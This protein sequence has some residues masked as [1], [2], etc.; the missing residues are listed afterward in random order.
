MVVLMPDQ[1][2]RELLTP[3]GMA[4]GHAAV[5]AAYEWFTHASEVRH[6]ER[7]KANGL[8]LGWPDGAFDVAEI[9]EAYGR[10]GQ[11][12]ICLSIFPKSS[13]LLLNKG[14]ASLFKVA[15][16]RD[17]LPPRVGI[18]CTFGGTYAIASQMKRD[19]PERT[20][21]EMFLAIVKDRE[22]VI[23]FDAIPASGLRVCPKA[24]PGAPPWEWPTLVDTDFADAAIFGPD[25]QGNVPV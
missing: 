13:I 21:G 25:I 22:I 23:S 9:I 2:L 3:E 5:V 15:L 1:F 16:P 17:S 4:D 24:A 10:A 12:I 14:D 11:N 20:R 8:L 7:I 6:F 19:F 18:D